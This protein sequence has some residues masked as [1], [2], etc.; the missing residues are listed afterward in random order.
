MNGRDLIRAMLN[1]L[2][3]INKLYE[4]DESVRFG[5]TKLLINTIS[6]STGV[7]RETVIEIMDATETIDEFIYEL[8]RT[9]VLA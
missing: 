1:E 4:H 3:D 8:S 5:A 9:P 2:S 7:E 6:Q